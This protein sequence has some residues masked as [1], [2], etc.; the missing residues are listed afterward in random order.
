MIAD[1]D[2][3]MLA[4]L[5]GVNDECDFVGW[6]R[7][8][9][10]DYTWDWAWQEYVIPR[11]VDF[12]LG[13]IPRL[14]IFLPPQHGK[15]SLVTIRFPAWLISQWPSSRIIL[16]AYNQTFAES[17]S[18]RIM[19]LM[20]EDARLGER[21]AAGEWE[22]A[23][24]GGLLAVGVGSG[25]TGRA[26][27]YMLI[28]DPIKSREEAESRAY[29]DRVYD[30][31][32]NDMYTRLQSY[33]PALVIQTRWHE[34]DLA[35]RILA[36]ETGSSWDVVRLPAV[37]EPGDPLGRAEGEALCP[38]RFNLDALADRRAVLGS[39]GFSALYQ[40]R[41]T[42]AEGGLIKRDWI[43]YYTDL[44]AALDEWVMSWDMSFE[45]TSSADYVVG[46]VWA[47]KGAQAYLV[48]QLRA[49][50]DFPGTVAAFRQMA[51]HYPQAVR[52]LVER[53]A[54]GHAVIHTLRNEIPGIVPI[55]PKLSKASRLAASSVYFE[56]GNVLLP[57]SAPWVGDYVEEIVSFPNAAHDD[58]CD[59][60]SQALTCLFHGKHEAAEALPE[61]EPPSP[62]VVV[63]RPRAKASY[64][65]VFA[66][67]RV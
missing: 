11:L 43:R 29:R 10:P 8:T 4:R 55:D 37:A 65:D 15:S 58:V 40:Q 63:G 50:L 33:S 28:D 16:G 38:D 1:T 6:L 56:A 24:G 59:A 35:G 51:A 57:Q 36:S 19:R 53:K 27:D 2:S 21:R 12:A 23:E 48:A 32:T 5:L 67:R 18:R 25:V 46:Q 45:D 52:K 47:R 44:P 61:R 66:L 62:R 39:Y 41:P 17:F 20:P 22:T 7:A 54:N 9:T 31:W 30:W 13:R 49:R 14:M 42:P 3:E 34:D 26:A 60:T 64:D